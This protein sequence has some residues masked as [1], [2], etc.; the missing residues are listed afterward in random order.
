MDQL[1][2]NNSIHEYYKD[3]NQLLDA[4]NLKEW[5]EYRF[6][7]QYSMSSAKHYKIK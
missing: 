3:V 2:Q 7:L 4:F 5:V 1:L 6:N